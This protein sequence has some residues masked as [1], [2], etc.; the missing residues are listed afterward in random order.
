MHVDA[1]MAPPEPQQRTP[2]EE[3]PAEPPAVVNV[4]VHQPPPPPPAIPMPT[5][6]PAPVVDD[7]AELKAKL[8]DAHVEIERLRM[9]ISSMPEPSTAPSGTFTSATPTE[10]RR[11]TRAISDDGSTISPETEVGSYVEEGI[12][13]PDGVPL[14]VVIVIMLGVYI[15]TYLFF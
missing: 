12:I 13:Q 10:L 3:P 4:S 8:R 1:P 11:R 2:I 15:V 14:Q 9:L 7:S 6:V 5:P